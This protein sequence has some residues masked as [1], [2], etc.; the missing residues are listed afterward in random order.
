MAS[1]D[2]PPSTRRLAGAREAFLA[3]EPVRRGVVRQPILASWARSR[4]H[5]VPVAG[6]DLG[7]ES[8]RRR[9]SRLARAALPVVGEVADLWATEPMSIIVC[10]ADGVVLERRTCDASLEQHL[11]RVWLAPGFSYA[12]HLVGTNGIGTALESRGP[13]H[14]FGHEHWVDSLERFACAAVPIRHPVTGKVEGVLNLTGWC[15]DANSLMVTTAGM[16]A[17]RVEAAL[18]QEAGRHELSLLG[19]YLAACHRNRGIVLAVGDDLLMLNDRA[20]ALLDP[21]DQE[22]LVASGLD[23]L[24][25][26]RRTAIDVDLP[27]GAT[28]RLHCRPCDAGPGRTGGVL[29]V[30]LLGALPDRAIPASRSAATPGPSTLASASVVG[31]GTLWTR[32]AQALDRHFAARE[33]VLLTGEPGSGLRTLARAVHQARTP[34]AHLRVLDAGE[35]GPGVLDDVAQELTRADGTV[36][37]TRLDLLDAEATVRLA[38][39]LASATSRDHRPWVAGTVRTA[40]AAPLLRVFPYTVEVPPLRHHLEDVPD[41]ARHF[42]G[43]LVRGGDLTLSPSALRMLSRH[44]WPGNV[45]QLHQVIRKVVARRRSGVIEVGDLPAEIWTTS[46]RAL[47]PLEAIEC[48]AIVR[49]L[50]QTGGSKAEAAALVGMSRAT[51]YRKVREYGISLS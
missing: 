12:E 6:P 33:W 29:L 48:D 5:D 16:L 28:A 40:P 47:T 9:E 17:R 25:G 36:V 1:T 7:T 50:L 15:R 51:I 10:D 41:L 39:L 42:I 23:A 27:S 49:A 24:R 38:E 45:G 21:A 4:E 44:P 2:L 11:D 34:A 35:R 30:Q 20:R 37:L 32:C 31:H 18:L 43:R 8:D 13:V 14:V 46:R 3:D 26:G 22:P 19:A